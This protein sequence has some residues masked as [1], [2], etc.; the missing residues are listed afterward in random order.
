M[1]S[2]KSAERAVVGLGW[3]IA[4]AWAGSVL[5]ACGGD[6]RAD[7]ALVDADATVDADAEGDA[8]LEAAVDDAA[9]LFDGEAPGRDGSDGVRCA[10]PLGAHPSV[11]AA[12]P[13]VGWRCIRHPTPLA[14]PRDVL[15]TRAGTVLLTEL[16]RG[17]IVSFST[18]DEAVTVIAAGLISP[19]G[20]RELDDD[21]LLVAE[22]SRGSIARIDRPTG[23]RTPI[24]DG[25]AAVTY[26]DLDARREVAFVSSFREVAPTGTGVVHRVELATGRAAPFLTGLHVPEGVVAEPSGGIVV[27]DWVVPGRVVRVDA[28]G[29]DVARTTELARDLGNVYGLVADGRGGFLVGDHRGRIEQ[30]HADGTVE[31][32][33]DGLGR[34]GGIAIADGRVFVAEFVD[35]GATG[36]LVELVG[37]L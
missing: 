18:R 12:V 15:V 11:G 14:A 5:G 21:T 27:A 35:F 1:R 30:V 9:V 17:R 26:V 25:L 19:I 29:G 4:A 32:L 7:A 8:A 23:A 13:R 36:Y 2:S 28:S 16:D 22:E 33:V 6:G 24:V 34:P 10:V 31:T 37:A 20:L 3:V